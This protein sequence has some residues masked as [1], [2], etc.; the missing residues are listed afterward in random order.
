M[1]IVQ[2]RLA[3]PTELTTDSSNVYTTPSSTVA[4]VKQVLFCNKTSFARTIT[5]RLVPFGQNSSNVYDIF[6]SLSIDPNETVSFACSLVLN[7]GDTLDSFCSANTS[8][9]LTIT[10]YEES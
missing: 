5:F 3:G 2:K 8:V 7:D 9:N 10:G 1:S 4:I 6:S